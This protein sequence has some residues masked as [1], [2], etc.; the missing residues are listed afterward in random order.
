MATSSLYDLPADLPVP[1]DDGAA[2]HLPGMPLPPLSLPATTGAE[3]RVDA[4]GDVV[5]FCYPRTGTPGA[6]PPGG[7]AGWD[8]IPGARGCTPQVCAYR[9]HAAEIRAAGY[10]ILGVSTQS[11]ADQR[12]A[13]GRLGISY[14]LLSDERLELATA[15]SL[16]TFQVAG[17]TLLRRLTLIVRDRQIVHVRY[18]VFPPDTDALEVLRWLHASDARRVE[19]EVHQRDTPT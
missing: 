14:P 2:R 11:P 17:K 8:A 6:E 15:L 13:A 9:D 1:V 7:A 10:D 18:P 3:I 4:I 16:P 5:V 19:A 12:E